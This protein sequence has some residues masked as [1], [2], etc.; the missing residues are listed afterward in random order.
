[1]LGTK[2]RRSKVRGWGNSIE[3]KYLVD[4]G[5]G[6]CLTHN[7]RFLGGLVREEGRDIEV[8][9]NVLQR[10]VFVIRLCGVVG[11]IVGRRTHGN[12]ANKFVPR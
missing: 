4:Y 9:S 11:C 8:Q 7:V 5:L 6:E 1:M 2:V 3:S 12:S 10:H